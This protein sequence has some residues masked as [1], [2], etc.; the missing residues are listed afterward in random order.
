LPPWLWRILYNTIFVYRELL[1]SWLKQ[2]ITALTAACIPDDVELVLLGDNTITSPLA[3]QAKGNLTIAEGATLALVANAITSSGKITNNGTVT[4]TPATAAALAALL[5]LIPEIQLVGALTLDTALEVPVNTELTIGTSGKITAESAASSTKALSVAGTVILYD[6][7]AIATAGVHTGS[8]DI[9]IIGNGFIKA[10][11][12]VISGAGNISTNTASGSFLTV[13]KLTLANTTTIAIT[14]S[15]IQ[16]GGENGITFKAGSYVF[17]N[18]SAAA[19]LK[20]DSDNP[21]LALPNT[22]DILAIGD[23]IASE[24]VFGSKSIYEAGGA[25]T[26]ITPG[27]TATAKGDVKLTFKKGAQ[28]KRGTGAGTGTGT[29]LTLGGA[30]TADNTTYT[31]KTDTT[32]TKSVTAKQ[33]DKTVDV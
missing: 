13:D 8:G 16:A 28:I 19:V 4:T 25:T 12:I 32:V 22:A 29:A 31:L 2:Y 1:F 21:T 27:D 11:G 24:L 18:V 30:V 17:G 3:I 15:Q 33:W 26:T 6:T 14:G 7:G 20:T 9:I 5:N 10:G 23:T